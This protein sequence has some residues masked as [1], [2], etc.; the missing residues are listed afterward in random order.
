MLYVFQ[1]QFT[2]WEI[3]TSW[4]INDSVHSLKSVCYIY[5]HET[6]LHTADTNVAATDIITAVVEAGS[7]AVL[8]PCVEHV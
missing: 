2:S 5:F 6:S 1:F 3:N 7:E 8:Q 4:R